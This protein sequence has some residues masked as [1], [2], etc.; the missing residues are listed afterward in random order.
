MQRC[1]HPLFNPRPENPQEE[2]DQA[3]KNLVYYLY[4]SN[5][6][7]YYINLEYI[8]YYSEKIKS[9]KD[10][11]F[12]MKDV[13]IASPL[14]S[15]LRQDQMILL[16]R[17]EEANSTRIQVLKKLEGLL[18]AII[19]IS[20]NIVKDNLHLLTKFVQNWIIDFYDKFG[21]RNN[22]D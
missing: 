13:Y 19:V 8:E 10:F 7:P 2:L 4:Y 11:Q 17:D 21:R 16:N 15:I 12:S 6:Y 22:L 9:N 3:L 14:E 18:N 20:E 5:A 1:N